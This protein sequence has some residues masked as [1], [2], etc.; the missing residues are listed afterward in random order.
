MQYCHLH[1]F[2]A[3]AQT[4]D[5]V[6]QKYSK[7]MGGLDAFNAIKTMKTTGYDHSQGVDLPLTVTDNKWKSRSHGCQAMGQSV[8][9]AYKDGKG[10]KIN[11]FAGAPTATDATPEELNE[12]KIQGSMISQLMDYKDRGYKVELHGQEDVEG[13]KLIKSSLT[14]DDNKIT[15][16]FIQL[17]IPTSL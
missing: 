2:Q 7:A 10:W 4:V 17:Q 6:I 11:P 15:T 14:T 12:F 3:N 9:N 8:I 1:L 13:L 5:D 16:Y